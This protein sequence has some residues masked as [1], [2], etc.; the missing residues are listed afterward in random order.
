MAQIVFRS[1]KSIYVEHERIPEGIA[2]GVTDIRDNQLDCPL[3]LDLGRIG[4][5]E[6]RFIVAQRPVL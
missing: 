6:V 2:A 5:F 1:A 3:P 4:Q